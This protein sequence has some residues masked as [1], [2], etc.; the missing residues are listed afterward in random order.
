MIDLR[1]KGL[2]SRIEW[3]G[4]SFPIRTDFRIWLEFGE[5]L[6]QKKLYLGIFDGFIPPEGDDWQLPAIR[7]YQS[8]NEV[9]RATRA[10]SGAKLLDFIIDG[11]FLVASFQQAYG[12]DLTTC[13]MHWHRF[14][15]LIDGLPDETKLA[16]VM[17]YRS[18]TPSDEKR[19][20]QDLM[21][22]Q[23]ARWALPRDDGKE[24]SEDD[25]GGFSAL[26]NAFG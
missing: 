2:P 24:G 16:K 8:P 10:P 6:K 14:C 13:D 20:H 5:W 9:P 23:R 15:A 18:W 25:M 1:T 7:F 21:L 4:G 26:L 17:G 3:D 19:K 22:E 11:P 12:I